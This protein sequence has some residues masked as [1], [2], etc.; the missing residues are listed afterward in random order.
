[1]NFDMDMVKRAFNKRDLSNKIFCLMMMSFGYS[2]QNLQAL[3]IRNKKYIKIKKKYMKY[4]KDYNFSGD[5]LS[6]KPRI[7][8][9]FCWFQGVDNAPEIVKACFTSIIKYTQNYN[10]HVINKDN[11]SNYTSIP[12]YVIQK[13]ERGIISNAHFADIIRTNILVRHGGLWID[14]TVLLTGE[15][16]EYVF[17]KPFF[18]FEMME[19]SDNTLSKNSWFI[20]SSANNRVLKSIQDLLFEYWKKEEVLSE[21]FLWHFFATMVFE[22]YPDDYDNIICVSEEMSHMLSRCLF[23]RYDEKYCNLIK[24]LSTIHKLSHHQFHTSNGILPL[25]YKDTFYEKVITGEIYE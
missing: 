11:Y 18:A 14:S 13:W 3:E 7:D 12:D 25:N 23:D 16:P 19:R 15:I 24:S 10:L 2:N 6:S 4:L 17:S 1:M 22:K 9:W 8:V 5:S 20:Y 21:Y